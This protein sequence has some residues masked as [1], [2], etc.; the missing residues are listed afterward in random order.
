[1]Y[2]LVATDSW[3]GEFPNM[4]FPRSGIDGNSSGSPCSKMA[5]FGNSSEF[6]YMGE[7]LVILYVPLKHP[8]LWL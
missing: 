3:G 7:F 8:L 5:F 1:M 2:L 4:E 6:P